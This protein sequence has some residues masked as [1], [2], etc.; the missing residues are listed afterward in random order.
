MQNDKVDVN[1]KDNEKIAGIYY[2]VTAGNYEI[3]ELLLKHKSEVNSIK[4]K[5]SRNL[6]MMACQ[7]GWTRLVK[8][9][10]DYKCDV[11]YQDPNGQSALHLAVM[12]KHQEVVDLLLKHKS[13]DLDLVDCV[14]EK[15]IHK[16]SNP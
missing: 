10:L 7:K 9:L 2:S 5:Q 3:T 4:D 6:V 14:K 1:Y 16:T 13:T 15:A 12:Y 8:L 11:N